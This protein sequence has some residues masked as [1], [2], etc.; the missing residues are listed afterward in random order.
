MA[1]RLPFFLL[2]VRLSSSFN[3]LVQMC[4]S[5]SYQSIKS[6]LLFLP[7]LVFSFLAPKPS[8]G[9]IF[10]LRSILKHLSKDS[11]SKE[12]RR[13]EEELRLDTLVAETSTHSHQ[14]NEKL[15]QSDQK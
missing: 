2:L 12:F 11:R 5:F 13:Q 10:V 3:M 4:A 6:L 1:F 14:H 8:Y 15:A 9:H 7:P